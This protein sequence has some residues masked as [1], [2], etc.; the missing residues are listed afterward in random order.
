MGRK[1]SGEKAVVPKLY[2]II[3]VPGNSAYAASKSTMRQTPMQGRKGYTIREWQ[4]HL[5]LDDHI[6]H[7]VTCLHKATE[8]IQCA[9]FPSFI[10]AIGSFCPAPDPKPLYSFYKKL[11]QPLTPFCF[12]GKEGKSYHQQKKQ[13]HVFMFVKARRFHTDCSAVPVSDSVKHTWL[14]KRGKKRNQI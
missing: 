11:S 8:H 9:D 12:L 14:K 7:S 13:H 1:L 10:P 3:Y 2:S 5:Q 4:P 6:I